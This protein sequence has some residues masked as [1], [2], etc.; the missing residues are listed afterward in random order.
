MKRELIKHINK[1]LKSDIN[2]G[3]KFDKKIN[4]YTAYINKEGKCYYIGSYITNEEAGNAYDLKAI[5]LYGDDA[6]TN[7]KQH[8]GTTIKEYLEIKRQ[9]KL[10]KILNKINNR[11]DKRITKINKQRLK[12]SLKTMKK[13]KRKEKHIYI[14]PDLFVNMTEEEKLI[15]LRTGIF[16]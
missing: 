13:L 12:N 1:Y 8:K 15:Y 10:F 3:V 7:Y 5:E 6:M 2:R 9:K 4:K 11:I 14:N 16:E